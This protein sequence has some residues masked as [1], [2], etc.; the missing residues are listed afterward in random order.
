MDPRSL[1]YEP[2]VI[3]F[4]SVLRFGSS[5]KEFDWKAMANDEP[6]YESL[7]S[8]AGQALD[9]EP[10]ERVEENPHPFWSERFQDEF[11]LQQRRPRELDM[12]TLDEEN[13]EALLGMG[14]PHLGEPPYDNELQGQFQRE[15]LIREAVEEVL[16]ENES[17]RRRVSD[18]EAYSSIMS[19]SSR[20]RH[21]ASS[22]GQSAEARALEPDYDRLFGSQVAQ[23]Q[24]PEMPTATGQPGSFLEEARPVTAMRNLMERSGSVERWKA[25]RSFLGLSMFMGGERGRDQASGGSGIPVSGP[26]AGSALSSDPGPR[27][28]YGSQREVNY[29]QGSDRPEGGPGT[30]VGLRARSAFR[31]DPPTPIFRPVDASSGRVGRTESNSGQGISTRV[32][33]SAPQDR[34]PVFEWFNSVTTSALKPQS[35]AGIALSKGPP[36]TLD[37]EVAL[38]STPPRPSGQ[39]ASPLVSVPGVREEEGRLTVDQ[40]HGMFQGCV[41]VEKGNRL[42][43]LSERAGDRPRYL[44]GTGGTSVNPGMPSGVAKASSPSA[45]CLLD[46]FPPLGLQSVGD[47]SQPP[48]GIHKVPLQSAYSEPLQASQPGTAGSIQVLRDFSAS[49][50]GLRGV[51]IGTQGVDHDYVPVV[52]MPDREVG[53]VHGYSQPPSLDLLGLE[54]VPLGS[55]YGFP[56]TSSG[57]TPGQSPL[58]PGAATPFVPV[59][60]P[61]VP[62]ASA[63]PPPPPMLFESPRASPM[64]P[65]ASYTPGGTR[66]PDGTPPQTPGRT[67]TFSPMIQYADL[68][69][70]VSQG[71]SI[72]PPAP[73]LALP[74]SGSTP[75]VVPAAGP[76][77]EEPSRLVFNLPQLAAEPGTQDASVAAGDWIARIRPVLTT[78]SQS[79]GG[80]WEETHRTAFHYYQRWLVGEPSERLTVRMEVEAYQRDWGHLALINERGAVLL[81][82]ALT[83][84][85]Q[86]E[87]VTTRMLTAVGLLFTVLVRYQPGGPTEKA[88]VLS[89]LSNPPGPAN[90]S[91]AQSSLRR[92]LRLYNRTAELQLHYPDPSL[93]M[94]GLDKL[95]H[96]VSR[97]GHATFRLASYRH[98]QRLDYEPS[99]ASVLAYAQVLLGEVEQQLL[100]QDQGQVEK[101]PRL[102]KTQVE[103]GQVEPKPKA[104]PAP[105]TPTPV[106]K[107]RPKGKPQVEGHTDD[108]EKGAFC[109]KFFESKDGCRYGKACRLTHSEIP[110]GAGRCYECG[111]STHLR[112]AC[113][114]RDGPE[115]VPKR[116]DQRARR[117]QSEASQRSLDTLPLDATEGNSSVGNSLAPQAK[118]PPASLGPKLSR[119]A[120]GEQ[121]GLLDGGATHALRPARSQWEYD[122]SR[123]LKVGLASGDTDSLRI[124]PGGTLITLSKETQPILPLGVAIRVLGM[125]VLWREDRCDIVHPTRGRIRVT[126]DKGCPEVPRALCLALIDELEQALAHSK[127]SESGLQALAVPQQRDSARLLEEALKA[128]CPFLALEAWVKEIYPH[129]PDVTLQ[130]CIPK[131]GSNCSQ[132]PAFNRH[133]RRK[134]ERGRTLLHLFSGSQDWSHES[135]SYTL[136][137]DKDRGWDLLDDGVYHY[138]FGVVLK[139]CVAAIVAGPP[140]RTWSRLR[141]L[142]DEG[143]PPLRSREG[144]ERFGFHD[145]DPQHRQMVQGD[146]LLL[147]RTLILMELLQAVRKSRK[148]LPGFLF[149]EHPADPATYTECRSVSQRTGTGATGSMIHR[150]PSIWAWVEVQQ[151]LDRMGAPCS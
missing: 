47:V 87:C 21:L 69:A 142:D 135:Y 123:P 34:D 79:A 66:V 126:L 137:I 118:A 91:E 129:L 62:L 39:S 41:D 117:Q 134:V 147:M 16:A 55:Q 46:S 125:S 52:H 149:L 93:L 28:R 140:C 84:D 130:R 83:A 64:M 145:L 5:F 20:D 77:I 71:G 13:G 141:R 37:S 127:V 22:S 54:P 36:P 32:E 57:L 131:P 56:S 17:L 45:P 4:Y 110:K 58:D 121:L 103:E 114:R 29:N 143:P 109:C 133:T 25:L 8:M 120:L 88:A 48:Q 102:L 107:S 14:I 139:G 82:G 60:V 111:A 108:K 40:Q 78:L 105:K 35:R 51:R 144:S 101:K 98:S 11:R 122:Q 128:H 146:T 116:R 81:L 86:T 95:S 18:L 30:Q 151:W 7:P 138:L 53:S 96:L 104:V 10:P 112:P 59:S 72:P 99:Q 94:K 132:H 65:Q 24:P 44:S 119:L 97:S 61:P 100:G 23:A 15:G 42:N 136:N 75:G 150:P 115:E 70:S 33:P 63:P 6:D 19:T 31:P 74:P 67:V 80:W 38:F 1:G 3:A 113:P 26:N 92:W 9:N 68:N 50:M 12:A 148:E 106:A 73:P 49:Q 124:N 2:K 85:L 76:R 27:D 43:G 90:M 89:F